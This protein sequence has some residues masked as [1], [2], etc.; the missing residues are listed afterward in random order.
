M[1][2]SDQE[3]KTE[4]PSGRRIGQ[5]RE[6]GNVPRSRELSTFAVTA[7]GLALL[8]AT[9][10]SIYQ[11]LLKVMHDWLSFDA[12]RAKSTD[13]ILEQ[14]RGS[15]VDAL[16]AMAPLLGGLFL[17]AALTPLLIGGWNFTTKAFMPNFGKLN[18]LSGIARLFSIQ[19]A[20]EGLKA[21]LKSLLIGGVAT[22]VIWGERGD[23]IGLISMPL[24]RA[25]IHLIGLMEHTF[26]IVVGA[27]LVLVLLDVPFQLWHYTKN[28]RMTKEEVKQ[29]YKEQ[30]GS[31]EVKGRIRQ[32]QREA[33][34][35]R[36]MQEIPNANVIITNPTHYAVAIH[37]EDGMAAPKLIAKGSLKMAEKIIEKGREHKVLVVR[38]PP[39]A[40]ALYF[41]VEL[42]EEVPNKL[43]TAAAQVL[44]YVHQLKHYEQQGG[45]SPV[46]P[47]K[48][49]VPPELDPETKHNQH[50]APS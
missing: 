48:L 5:A 43:Y 31:P 49:E 45:I 13:I 11:Y 27:M 46:F 25:Q 35:R 37:Y 38:A 30:E 50:T 42:G 47:E 33:A 12:A 16:Q 6:E 29:E 14:F 36:M 26:Q 4:A 19:A 23:L 22:W 17:V 1:A 3:D 34:R 24:D 7:T 18:P 41:N 40:R 44:A 28:L 10:E 2:D 32:L 20:S 8:M 39:F 15:L 21:L 9:G